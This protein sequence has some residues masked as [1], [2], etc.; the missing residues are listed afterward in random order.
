MKVTM[1]DKDEEVEL[2]FVV[3]VAYYKDKWIFVRHKERSTYEIPGGHIESEE[4]VYEAGK[5]ELREETGATDFTLKKIAIYGVDKNGFEDYGALFL[6]ECFAFEPLQ[7][8]IA[9][10]KQFDDIP[11]NLTYPLIQPYL[12]D[13]AKQVLD[14]TCEDEQSNT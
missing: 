6:A 5:R 3:I 13:K 8:E 10:I 7:Y 12:F 9:E 1:Y 14:S 2:T 11:K 4:T